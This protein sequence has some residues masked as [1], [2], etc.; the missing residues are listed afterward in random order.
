MEVQDYAGVVF[1][2]GFLVVGVAQE[3]K[4]RAVRA[5][6]RFYYVG[7]VLLVCDGVDIAQI[8]AARLN[9]LIEVV[10]RT[11][12]YSPKLAPAEGEFKLEIGCCLGVE[13]KLLGVVVAKSEVFFLYAKLYKPLAAEVFPVVKPLEVGAGLAEKLKLHLLELAYAEDEIS[14]SYLVA[15]ALA[16]LSYS[17]RKL[18][19]GGALY[20][21]EV[22]KYSLR[23]FGAQIYRRRA[24]LG[25]AYKRLEHK[26]EFSHAREVALSAYGTGDIMLGYVRLHLLVAPARDVL[27]YAVLCHIVLYKVIRT[28]TG[29][30]AL[31]VHKRVG[32]AAD[33]SRRLPGCRVHKYCAVKSYVVRASTKPA[34]RCF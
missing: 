12:G 26:I 17:E 10:I 7:H 30:A 27:F 31:A 11:V 21:S 24:V 5:E 23:G 22:Y 19:T 3:R 15:E 32:K 28:V 13:A 2:D 9:V 16:Y 8:L 18:F 34:L 6:R 20:V 33:V 14:R 4:E 25:Y 1:S 29:F